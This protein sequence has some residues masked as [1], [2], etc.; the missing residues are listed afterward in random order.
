MTICHQEVVNGNFDNA[1]NAILK[2][3][4]SDDE[5]ELN[6]SKDDEEDDD[7]MIVNN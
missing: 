7:A 6:D 5:D 1:T 3:I 4:N 2:T